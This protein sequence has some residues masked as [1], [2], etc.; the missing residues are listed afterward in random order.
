MKLFFNLINTVLFLSRSCQGGGPPTQ[1]LRVVRYDEIVGIQYSQVREGVKSSKI[2][3]LGLQSIF[4]ILRGL[5]II[6][7]L[8]PNP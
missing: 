3:C 2:Y 7:V 1:Q 6:L 4:M 5:N 8:R